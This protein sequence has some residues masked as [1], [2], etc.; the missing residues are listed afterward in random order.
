MAQ[1]LPIIIGFMICIGAALVLTLHPKF[2][3]PDA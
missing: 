3:D 1:Q 2:R